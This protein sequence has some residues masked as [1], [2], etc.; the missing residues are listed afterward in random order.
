[1]HNLT[2]RWY[3][4]VLRP[5]HRVNHSPLVCQ[6]MGIAERLLV[7][8]SG[9]QAIVHAVQ[10]VIG[11]ISAHIVLRDVCIQVGFQFECGPASRAM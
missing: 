11:F 6:G 5:Y 9:P 1:V 7:V 2:R 4:S 3:L 8:D 10:S